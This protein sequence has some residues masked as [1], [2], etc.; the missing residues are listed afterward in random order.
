MNNYQQQRGVVLVTSIIM[1]MMGSLMASVSMRASTLSIAMATQHKSQSRSTHAARSTI[2]TLLT[3][4]VFTLTTGTTSRVL[5]LPHDTRVAVDTRHVGVTD[6]VASALYD[7]NRD[8]DLRMHV[9]EVTIVATGQRGMTSRQSQ[10]VYIIADASQTTGIIDAANS[11]A[12]A[13][14]GV[15]RWLGA[16]SR[17]S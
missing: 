17:T 13:R 7:A 3:S 2:E 16:W 12:I 14:Y 6:Q 11:P 1:I 15:D 4:H 8:T 9:F 10:L 5:T